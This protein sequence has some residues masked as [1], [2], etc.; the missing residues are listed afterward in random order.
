MTS[1]YNF[2]YLANLKWL[3]NDFDGHISDVAGQISGIGGHASNVS[4]QMSKI[5]SGSHL[6]DQ[7]MVAK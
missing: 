3:N 4:G 7:S 6:S 5:F 1:I 2:I